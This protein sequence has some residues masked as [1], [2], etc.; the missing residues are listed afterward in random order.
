MKTYLDK[1]QIILGFILGAAMFAV[2]HYSVPVL[3]GMEALNWDVGRNYVTADIIGYKVRDCN[4]IKGSSVGYVSKGGSFY[5][6]P[7]TFAD[8]TAA[9]PTSIIYKINFG[10]WNWNLEDKDAAVVSVMTTL[11]FECNGT[12]IYERAGP[13]EIPKE[14]VNGGR[15]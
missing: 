9:S 14:K 3:I 8:S 11:K 10:Q 1:L 13:F 7:V 12:I 5:E 6:V 15:I 4:F 2:F